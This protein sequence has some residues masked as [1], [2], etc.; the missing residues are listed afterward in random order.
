MSS[1]IIYKVME[2]QILH[3][4]NDFV[5]ENEILLQ[6]DLGTMTVVTG[7]K[8][9]GFT[10]FVLICVFFRDKGRFSRSLVSEAD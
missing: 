2:C 5:G 4:R 3:T 7:N 6:L 9:F 10:S 1:F 8:I